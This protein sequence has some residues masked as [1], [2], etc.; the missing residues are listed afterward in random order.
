M[1]FLNKTTV[2]QNSPQLALVHPYQQ[3]KIYP[4]NF[5]LLSLIAPAALADTSHCLNNNLHIKTTLES[6]MQRC[7]LLAMT[8][9]QGDVT[10]L[11]P[12]AKL[13]TWPL[14]LAVNI[15]HLRSLELMT[16]MRTLVLYVPL[17][18]R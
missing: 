16:M 9:R 12:A 11:A 7:T 1:Q 17:R 8:C 2:S 10:S 5:H 6:K 13:T 15:F 3:T 4:S 18:G 14:Q